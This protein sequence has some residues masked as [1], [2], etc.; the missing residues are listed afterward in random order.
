[1][2]RP[3]PSIPPDAEAQHVLVGKPDQFSDLV[4]GHLL[5]ALFDRDRGQSG[6]G[7]RSRDCGKLVPVLFQQCFVVHPA[8]QALDRQFDSGRPAPGRGPPRPIP[9]DFRGC[10][11][12]IVQGRLK[13]RSSLPPPHLSINGFQDHKL[14]R[15]GKLDRLQT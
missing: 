5:R 2:Q 14:L 3:W 7:V 15:Y 10:D 9:R 6:R 13:N 11:A 4:I 1:M 12:M 8:Q